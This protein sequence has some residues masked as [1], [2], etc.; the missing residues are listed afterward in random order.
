ML[1]CPVPYATLVRPA[2]AVPPR[3]PVHASPVPFEAWLNRPG[4]WSQRAWLWIALALPSGLIVWKVAGSWLL[5]YAAGVA[6]A[7][8]LAW[9]WAARRGTGSRRTTLAAAALTALALVAAMAVFYPRFNT[10]VPGLGADDDDAL[11]V[12]VRALVAGR[13]PYLEQTYLGN[14]LHQL[15]GAFV[16]AAPFT[17]ILGSS[18]WQ[19][20][21][22]LGAFWIVVARD[23]RNATAAVRLSWVV[24]IAS[25]VVLHG[26]LTGVG[27][28][29]N[30]LSVLLGMRWL[31]AVPASGASTSAG[32]RPPWLAALFWGVALAARPNFLFLM[33]LM[34][35]WLWRERGPRAAVAGVGLSAAVVAALS[36]P[37]LWVGGIDGFTPLEAGHA[38]RRFDGALPLGFALGAA[39]VVVSL[40][41]ATLPLSEAG[42][43]LAAAL[44]M[45][46]PVVPGTVLEAMSGLQY[47]LYYATW[48]VFPMWFV[49][50]AAARGRWFEDYSSES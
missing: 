27:H 28:M 42:V 43:F 37:F 29:A 12:G 24:L 9:R 38:L 18:A 44:V 40:W 17:L 2:R 21:F 22:W 14:T 33:P 50:L 23:V 41:C 5:A 20:L 19:N 31:M 39:L 48:A 11:N 46:V 36:V 7:A 34:G 16:L 1:W 8:P 25:P 13:S 47:G 4:R 45:A 32:H 10:A 15:P 26:M 35:G 6:L 3:M 30:T 49:L